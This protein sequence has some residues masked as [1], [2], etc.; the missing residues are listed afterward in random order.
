MVMLITPPNVASAI[1]LNS[2]TG[3]FR[4]SMPGLLCK[5]SYSHL[6]QEMM[7]AR[8]IAPYELAP[9]HLQGS[10]PLWLQ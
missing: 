3:R 5:P 1:E 6:I 9:R 4:P 10:L 8:S 7:L 2:E